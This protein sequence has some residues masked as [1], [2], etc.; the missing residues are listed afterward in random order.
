MN[1]VTSKVELE[2]AVNLVSKALASKVDGDL[3]LIHISAKDDKIKL[4]TS[5]GEL[6][7]ESTIDAEVHEDG[8]VAVN[9]KLFCDT[10][11]KIAGGEVEISKPTLKD[12]FWLDYKGGKM[13]MPTLPFV[14][15]KVENEFI[16]TTITIEASKFKDIAKKV[17][18]CV[19]TDI[20]RPLLRGVNIIT[21]ENKL[22]AVALDGYRMSKIETQTERTGKEEI[23]IIVPATAINAIASIVDSG[24]KIVFNF[25]AKGNVVIVIY[26]GCIIT[27]KL[28]QGEFVKYEK[29]IPATAKHKFEIDKEKL[30]QTF[31]RAN[32][33]GGQGIAKMFT[34]VDDFCISSLSESGHIDDK[35]EFNEIFDKFGGFKISVSIKF[36]LQALKTISDKTILLKAT[37]PNDPFT[38]SCTDSGN[39]TLF[40]ILPI[41]T[42]D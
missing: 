10:V 12:C 2:Y 32:L 14:Y 34:E 11:H 36:V 7:I 37:E 17:L 30:L 42:I 23:N 40:L 15:S 1:A 33:L 9:G 21:K 18:S 5:N 41:R 27:A 8:D 16:D 19:A 29:I 4:Y 22:I 13:E 31:E 6:T 25:S 24:T 28:Y 20:T 35:I 26:G 38:I 39:E 3:G